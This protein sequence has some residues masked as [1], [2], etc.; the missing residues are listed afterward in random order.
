MFNPLR[1]TQETVV[2]SWAAGDSVFEIVANPGPFKQI[3][4]D[5]FIVGRV[6]TL[7]EDTL[8]VTGEAYLNESDATTKYG[9]SPSMIQGHIS[10][11]FHSWYRFNLSVCL[12]KILTATFRV[13]VYFVDATNNILFEYTRCTRPGD[14][15]EAE[16]TW[17]EYKTGSSWSV[18]GGDYEGGAPL[19]VTHETSDLPDVGNWF[20]LEG[21]A[22]FAQDAIDNRS[23]VFEMIGIAQA[24]RS[25]YSSRTKEH[26][27]PSE[28]VVTSSYT[29]TKFHFEGHLGLNLKIS[30][31]PFYISKSPFH[32]TQPIMFPYNYSAEIK[33]TAGTDGGS[34]M[35]KY[36]IEGP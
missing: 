3:V 10:K 18:A 35:L 25:Y 14:V 36:H 11:A 26:G 19:A 5:E 34:Y 7:Q 13:Y 9:G 12:P 17:N 2:G 16:V 20:E 24:I 23:N 21:F 6:V 8:D 1:H 22:P 29:H 32:S 30:A 33:P 15:V 31:G 27:I 4:I 28:L